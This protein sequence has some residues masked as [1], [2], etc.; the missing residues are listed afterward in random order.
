MREKK[1]DSVPDQ[2]CHSNPDG[3]KKKYVYINKQILPFFT[4]IKKKLGSMASQ[5]SYASIVRDGEDAHGGGEGSSSSPLLS[6]RKG[7][8]LNWHDRI[9]RAQHFARRNLYHILTLFTVTIL[10]IVLLVYTLLPD[11]SV[12]PTKEVHSVP[13]PIA[14]GVS[15]LTMENGRIQCEAIQTRKREKDTPSKDRKNP[16]AEANQQPI[17]LKNAV[18]WDGQGNVLHHV[19]VYMEDGII[20]KVEKDV[21]VAQ[22]VKVIDVAG[23]VVGPGL[24]DMHR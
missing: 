9:R 11:S 16:R 20:Q 5:P 12:F 23:H 22:H 19:D 17:L 21:K 10:L 2:A 13:S 7:K 6:S 18:V 8:E 4:F 15:E 24:V 3:E 14:A 1:I